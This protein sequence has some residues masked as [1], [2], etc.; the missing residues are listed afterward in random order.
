MKKL[1][2]II[3][4]VLGM[5]TTSC[6]DKMPTD[7]Y[8]QKD[9]MKTFTDAEQTVNGIYASFK[10][11]ALHSG[12]L[13]VAQDIQADLVHKVAG[14]Q[15]NTFGTFWD[16][17]FLPNDGQITGV[18]AQLYGIIGQCNFFL[19]KADQVEANLHTDEQFDLFYSMKGEVYFA[20]AFAYSE[21]IRV[22]CKAYTPE[23]GDQAEMGVVLSTS[24]TTKPEP[25]R[26][27]LNESYKLVLDDLNMAKNLINSPGNVF[28]AIY[29]TEG[30][31]DALLARVHLYMQNW[32]KAIEHS[33]A[34]IEDEEAGYEL[35]NTNPYG[36][37][38]YLTHLW[39]EDSSYEVIFKVGFTINSYGGA[40]GAPFLN[41]NFVDY[42]PVY[43]PS[44]WALNLYDYEDM[45]YQTYFGDQKTGYEHGLEW[46]L[47]IKYLGN[48]T[49]LNQNIVGVN[50][51]KIFRLAEQYLIRAEAYCEKGAYDLASADITTIHK[52]RFQTASGAN[53][54]AENWLDEISDERVRELFMEGHRLTDLKR[55]KK[56]FKREEQLHTQSPN[57]ELKIEATDHRFVW[58]IPLHEVQAPGSK[59]KQNEGY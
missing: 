8:L 9:A 39:K 18:Y 15:L 54:N 41:Y 46:P 19:E 38:S 25:I 55:W 13:T 51:P 11:S 34:V 3:L 26:A 48:P 59:V 42:R 47:L 43:V 29:F 30:T 27:T 56:G 7:A 2:I 20:R 22:F 32:D 31:V 6:L 24:Y 50:M 21:L 52:A 16:W 58:P 36:E 4:A 49:F 5:T 44:T 14:D 37:G 35:A 57:N 12:T 23:I 33:T 45:R 10:S 17:N 28:N 40:L 53:L 1:Y